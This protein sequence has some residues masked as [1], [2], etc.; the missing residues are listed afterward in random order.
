M[1]EFNQLETEVL[2]DALKY[3]NSEIIGQAFYKI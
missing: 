1:L 2:S 3:T